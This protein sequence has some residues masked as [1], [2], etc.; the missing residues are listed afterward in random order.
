MIEAYII[1]SLCY[2]DDSRFTFEL[3]SLKSPAAT[4]N[5]GGS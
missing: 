5:I 4:K 3:A 1:V 2:Y